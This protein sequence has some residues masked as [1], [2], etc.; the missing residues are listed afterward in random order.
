MSISAIFGKL[1]T[2][3]IRTE[4]Q[5]INEFCVPGD[6]FRFGFNGKELDDKVNSTGGSYDFGARIYDPRLGRFYT[7]DFYVN[8]QSWQSPYLFANNSPIVGV[9]V[10]G[11][12]FKIYA[13]AKQAERFQR[14]LQNKVGDD[15]EV[16]LSLVQ[17]ADDDIGGSAE[18]YALTIVKTNPD[19]AKGRAV[20]DFIK[21]YEGDNDIAL[22][23]NREE[24][25]PDKVKVVAGERPFVWMKKGLEITRTKFYRSNDPDKPVDSQGRPRNFEISFDGNADY[26][27]LNYLQKIEDNSS[28]DVIDIIFQ[29]LSN[30]SDITKDLSGSAMISHYQQ[31]DNVASFNPKVISQG[32]I[33]Y[34]D[35]K[36]EKGSVSL[37]EISHTYNANEPSDIQVKSK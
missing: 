37:K 23:F 11:T 5:P 24:G 2:Q 29:V 32:S 19:P 25:S 7:L 27:N 33:T 20:Y 1:P 3:M 36:G 21:S 16:R 13:S 12:V 30:K 6:A 15:Y 14:K 9:D 31:T 28:I 4:Y 10:N 8:R 26:F 17:P 18:F 22:G 35:S 34:S